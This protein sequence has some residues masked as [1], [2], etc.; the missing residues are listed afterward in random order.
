MEL[1]RYTL[2]DI[3]FESTNT[4]IY[5]AKRRTD[6]LPTVIKS[7]NSDHPTYE[8][9]ARLKL[10][11][12]ILASLNA[13][14]KSIPGVVRALSFESVRD[15]PSIVMEDF[16]ASDLSEQKKDGIALDVFFDIAPRIVEALGAIHQRKIIHKDIN[17]RNIV[18][19]GTTKEVKLIDFNIAS[20]LSREKQRLDITNLLEGSIDYISPEQT[21]RTNRYIDYRTDYYS[22]GVTFFELLTGQLPFVP[23]DTMRTLH[24]HLSVRPDA[25]KHIRSDIPR[26]LSQLVLKLMEKNSEDRYQS[27]HGIL[28][29]LTR[30]KTIW[31]TNRGDLDFSLGAQDFSEI[32]LIPDK[33]Y[34]REDEIKAI[35]DGYSKCEKGGSAFLLVAGGAGIGKSSLISEIQT[36]IVNRNGCFVSGKFEQLERNIPFFAITQ[37]IRSLIEIIMVEPQ[38]QLDQWKVALADALGHNARLLTAIIPELSGLMG[39]LPPLPTLSVEESQNRLVLTF[40]NFL[41]TCAGP[42]RPLVIFLDDLQWGDASSLD[43]CV[44]WLEEQIPYLMII[45]AYRDNEVDPQL[46]FHNALDKMVGREET[47]SKQ[48]TECLLAPLDVAAIIRMISQTVHMDATAC[49]PLGELIFRKTEG[50]PFFVRELL[51]SLYQKDYIQFDHASGSWIWD[52][53]AIEEQ[54]VSDNVVDLLV[55]RL[56]TLPERTLSALKLAAFIGYHFTLR[57]LAAVAESPVA[58]MANDLLIPIQMGIL[59]PLNRNYKLVDLEER[60]AESTVDIAYAF[61]HDRIEQAVYSLISKSSRALIHY[62]IGSLLN[63]VQSKNDRDK[64]L[65]VMVNHLN[66]GTTVM[67]TSTELITLARL[68]YSAGKKAKESAAYV[69]AAG[70]FEAGLVALPAQSESQA[71]GLRFQ[72]THELV[73]SSY[74]FGENHKALEMCNSLF[75]LSDDKIDLGRAS[76]LKSI[77]QEYQGRHQKAIDTIREGL[78]RIGVELLST[79]KDIEHRTNE[80]IGE[81][82]AYF[83][84][85]S[86][87]DLAALP[88]MTDPIRQL[89]LEMLFRAVPSALQAYPPLFVLIEL[90]MFKTSTEYGISP[91]SI[92]NFVDCGIIQGG[93][94]GNYE[95]AYDLG[96]VS[97]ELLERYPAENLR[98]SVEFVFATYISH[99]RNPVRE[100]LLYFDKAYQS[101]LDVGDRLIAAYSTVYRASFLFYSGV[102]LHEC[103]KQIRKSIEILRRYNSKQLLGLAEMTA[104]II[105]TFMNDVPSRDTSA[106]AL[107]DAE[108]VT[109]INESQNVVNIC[110]MGVSQAVMAYIFGHDEQVRKWIALAEP[111]LMSITGWFLL[112]DYYL[113]QGLNLA[114]QYDA[115]DTSSKD[116]T[117]LETIRENVS[118]LKLWADSC[119]ENFAHKY[120]L[121]NA[122]LLRIEKYPLEIILDQYDKAHDSVGTDNF[123]HMKAMGFECQA[124]FWIER[125]NQLIAKAHM[126]EARNLYRQW[127]AEAKVSMLEEKYPD[128]FTHAVKDRVSHTLSSSVESNAID[129]ASILKA[130]L[131]VS[132]AIELDKL[133]TNITTTMME[134]AGA[135][136][137]V[138]ILKYDTKDDLVI[139]AVAKANKTVRVLQSEPM[140]TSDEVSRE[141]VRFVAR[142]RKSLLLNNAQR[143]GSFQKSAYVVAGNVK[144]VLCLPLINQHK[145]KAIVYLENNLV[146]H[147]FPPDRVAVLKAI[148]SPAAVTLENA[149]MY[150]HLDE[151]VV[152]RTAELEA[153][154][155]ELAQNAHIAGMS[156]IAT[157][158][159][160]NVGNVL[161]SLKTA[162]FTAKGAAQNSMVHRLVKANAL[163]SS[164]MADI[165][166]FIIQNPKGKKLLKYYIELG[167]ILEKENTMIVEN[168]DQIISCTASISEII[169][170][171]QSYAYATGS[172]SE[173]LTIDKIIENALTLNSA[174]LGRHDIS[175]EKRYRAMPKIS[176][177]KSKTLH[178]ILNLLKNAKEAMTD[179]SIERTV[180]IETDVDD[181][182]LIVKISDTGD[183]IIKENLSKIFSFGFTTKASGHGSGLHSSANYITEMG[184]H[185]WADSG[186]K[187]KG[188]TFGLKFPLLA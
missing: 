112:A 170:A 127:G 56:N 41:K 34:G 64:N 15:K 168:V 28:T 27:S 99:W 37:S 103:R 26:S 122:E 12:D 173:I 2:T 107:K 147:A 172:F 169:S 83:S 13:A 163:L 58:R 184:G 151:L 171:Q 76:I 140:E 185:I 108:I 143:D 138:L 7:V 46:P 174:S 81:M 20:E 101:A 155:A 65:F 5:R 19:N 164:Q 146:S 31:E 186:G 8:E 70:Y 139:E 125:G 115:G 94:L 113:V 45:G 132:S 6:E 131:S 129:V 181:R 49:E 30:C 135:E 21:G 160:H 44:S 126:V 159:L 145:L 153:A 73:E 82:Q 68:N 11:Y 18:M 133:L 24:S 100:A 175:I 69:V 123:I 142:S 89:E 119:P 47:G 180:V 141:I 137:S 118:K 87:S 86:V 53:G 39:A 78:R 29:D 72:L 92:K 14:G 59:L 161:N 62:R 167:T 3:L 178:I 117:Y 144:S 162:G 79:P 97:F 66:L 80:A 98:P 95:A 61:Q 84:V 179:A 74:I 67:D 33:L 157:T 88:E 149:F 134:N 1:S 22:L 128:W 51:L 136:K 183:G 114:K 40:V 106:F 85:N 91:Y 77:I 182:F 4:I 71:P 35:L 90:M 52:L 60:D 63:G 120:H 42:K 156:E 176:L 121:L 32:F 158:V 148:A 154:Q 17:P 48:A 111:H 188:A 16:G 25:P 130:T 55:E 166:S 110:I 102:R 75:S 57:H 38:E 96:L 109:G 104:H 165:E 43:L 124:L 9:L 152:Q 187:G 54:S 105:H 93:I 116:A 23:G 50:N 177:H 10:E 150:N 36:Y